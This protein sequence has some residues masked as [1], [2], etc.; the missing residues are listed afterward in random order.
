M[1]FV[2]IIVFVVCVWL[3]IRS[4]RTR[5]DTSDSGSCSPAEYPYRPDVE[6]RLPDGS[7]TTN[8]YAARHPQ[9]FEHWMRGPCDVYGENIDPRDW[10]D[11]RVN[12]YGM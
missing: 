10:E 6:S 11:W 1:G 12:Y 2:Y 4:F 7:I 5:S 3:L 9:E 8:G